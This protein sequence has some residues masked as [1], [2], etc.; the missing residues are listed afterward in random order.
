MPIEPPASRFVFEI[1]PADLADWSGDL[2][3][4][5]GDLEP[6]TLLAAYRNGFFP[7]GLEDGGH[8]PIGW[9]SPVHR[10]V[11]LPGDHRVHRSLRR[12]SRRFSVTVDEAFDDVV[13]GCAD[14]RRDGAWITDRFAEAYGELHRLGWAHSVEVWDEAGDLAGGLYGVAIGALFAGESMFHRRTDASKVA[15]WAAADLVFEAGATAAIFDVQWSTPH[16]A[17]QGVREI[18]RADYRERVGRAVSEP[19]PRAFRAASE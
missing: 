14:P 19:L 6:G 16:L 4:S 15:L 9:W 2:V 1:D 17:A 5:G 12:T 7:M 10:G 3:A 13:A 18:P 8:G 11:L